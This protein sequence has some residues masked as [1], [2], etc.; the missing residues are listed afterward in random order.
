M[1]PLTQEEAEGIE[2]CLE[3]IYACISSEMSG[4]DQFQIRQYIDVAE[5]GL[6][7]D[8]MVDVLQEKAKPVAPDL[9]LLLLEAAGKMGVKPEDGW[10]GVDLL[11]MPG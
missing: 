2:K 9:R 7:L 1:M 5:Y 6:A 3:Q 11:R 8:D 4:N 10:N